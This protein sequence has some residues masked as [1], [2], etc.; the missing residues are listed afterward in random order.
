MTSQSAPTGATPQPDG[1]GGRAGVPAAFFDVDRT[2]IAG[3]SALRMAQPFRKGGLVT[4]RQQLR[5]GL[6]QVA[7][8]LLGADD[9]EIE[10]FASSVR[11]MIAGWDREHMH[12]VIDAEL[13]RRVRPTVYRE[14][15]ERISMHQRQGHKVFAVSATI[16]DII[17]PLAEMLGLDGAVGSELEVHDGRL[18]GELALPC[19]GEHKAQRLREFATT[20]GIDLAASSAYSDSI[21][22]EHF[23]RAVGRPYAVNPD[24]DLRKLAED[25]GWGVLFFR[26]QMEVPLHRRRA[27]RA[28]VAL[29]LAAAAVGHRRRRR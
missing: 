9:T 21:S 4:R 29:V 11:D 12:R 14:A 25:E 16:I 19:H 18:T 23:L 8:S 10:R 3:A 5:A 17:A 15:M 7:F 24:R 22:D 27:T 2:L 26:Q 1:R 6:N 28:S 20:H 13:D